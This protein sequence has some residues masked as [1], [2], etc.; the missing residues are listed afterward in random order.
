MLDYR[1]LALMRGRWLGVAIFVIVGLL[2]A[3]FQLEKWIDIMSDLT[4]IWIWIAAILLGSAA[5]L[6]TRKIEKKPTTLNWESRATFAI[7]SVFAYLTVHYPRIKSEPDIPSPTRVRCVT[8][9]R[10]KQ[11]FPVPDFLESIIQEHKINWRCHDNEKVLWQYLTEHNTINL[12][13]PIPEDLGL[14]FDRNGSLVSAEDELY[15]ELISKLRGHKLENLQVIY[16]HRLSLP[17]TVRR[18][19][20]LE[21]STK[22]AFLPPSCV[23]ELVQ[24]GIIASE[25]K[26]MRPWEN[27]DGWVKR[28]YDFTLVPWRYP[29]SKLSEGV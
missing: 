4:S 20:L 1:R 5:G 14:R 15:S 6:I 21:R 2:T 17:H 29:E 25:S 22:Q 27:C 9:N 11:A 12:E 19:L 16:L 7:G 8:Y 18:T 10:K 28:V 3:I 26:G 13:D 24:S 23:H